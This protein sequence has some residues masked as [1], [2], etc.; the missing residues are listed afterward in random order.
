[1]KQLED[2]KAMKEGAEF[3]GES[4]VFLV[5]GLAIVFEYNRSQAKSEEK[6]EIKRAQA[7]AEREALQA[8]LLKINERL[9]AMEKRIQQN[10]LRDSPSNQPEGPSRT[11]WWNNL[12]SSNTP[13][14]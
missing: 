4:V 12:F 6:D 14:S 3:L 5:S 10:S 9:E 1:M 2:E 7:K 13:G 11:F 8:Q